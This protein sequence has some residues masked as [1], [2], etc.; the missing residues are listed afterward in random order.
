MQKY[1]LSNITC[2]LRDKFLSY[3]VS[4]KHDFKQY[5]KN[6]VIEILRVIYKYFKNPKE[7]TVLD[8][9]CS[10]VVDK[11]LAKHVKKIVGINVNKDYLN[12]SSP[13]R[14]MELLVMDGEKL[15]FAEKTFDFI[16]STNVY[17]HVGNFSQCLDE[18]LRV[19][20]NN[21]YCYARWEPLW[22]SQRGHHMHDDMARDWEKFIKIEETPYQNNGRFIEDWAHLLLSQEEMAE[23]LGLKLGNARLSQKMADYVYLSKDINR[24]FFEDFEKILSAK[25]IIIDFWK[26]RV[27]QPPPDILKKLRSKH[28]YEDF[29]TCSCDILFHKA[30]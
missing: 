22:S 10:A 17:E 24:L 14:N 2:K 29:G 4:H 21:G 1:S 3:E 7:I 9:G 8:F 16:Y 23:N 15:A 30:L 27:K 26:K 6:D 18:Q 11:Y 12:I 13:A 19:L 28:P 25:K 5:Q 20:K